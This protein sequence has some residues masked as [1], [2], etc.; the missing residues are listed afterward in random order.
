VLEGDCRAASL[1]PLGAIEG[2]VPSRKVFGRLETIEIHARRS[3][4][5]IYV[6]K[7]KVQAEEVSGNLAL[8]VPG[9]SEARRER[10]TRRERLS[11]I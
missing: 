4:E 6:V 3:A 2:D 7:R 10:G 8:D 5:K 1:R 9:A 11:G